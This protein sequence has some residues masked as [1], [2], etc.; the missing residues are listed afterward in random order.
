[1]MFSSLATNHCWHDKT[2]I[3]LLHPFYTFYHNFVLLKVIITVIFNAAYV[4]TS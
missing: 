1:M 3:D 2:I 4:M